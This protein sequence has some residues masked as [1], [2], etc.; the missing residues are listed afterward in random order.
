[1]K[2]K[3]EK[4]KEPTCQDCGHQT[5]RP[6]YCHKDEKFVARKTKP[7]DNFK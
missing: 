2:Q 5:N 7:C 1:M 4:Q 3:D 6:S